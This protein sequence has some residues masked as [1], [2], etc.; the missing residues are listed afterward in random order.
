MARKIT[1]GDVAIDNVVNTNDAER[2]DAHGAIMW[3]PNGNKWQFSF[4]EDGGIDVYFASGRRGS[5]ALVI[6]PMSANTFRVSQAPS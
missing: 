3:E 1:R 6:E 2:I 4:S 5:S